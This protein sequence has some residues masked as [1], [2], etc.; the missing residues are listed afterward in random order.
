MNEKRV[1]WKLE[2]N[3]FGHVPNMINYQMVFPEKL[4]KGIKWTDFWD[5]DFAVE[6][7]G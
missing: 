6:N 7:E 4:N 1:D 2:C 3:Q 5:F